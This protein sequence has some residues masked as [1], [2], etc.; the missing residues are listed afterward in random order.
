MTSNAIYLCQHG[1]A[2]ASEVDPDRPLSEQGVADISAMSAALEGKVQ[3]Q[4]IVHSGKTRARQTAELFGKKLAPEAEI[5]IEAG[6]NPNDPAEPCAAKIAARPTSIMVVSHLPFVGK[7]ACR[8]LTKNDGDILAF[9]PGAVA[10]LSRDANGNSW[11]LEWMLTPALLSS[12][13]GSNGG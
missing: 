5:K 9:E 8:L 7:L 12:R 11:R 6:L 10:A 1:D 3:I 13:S 4:T 2:L